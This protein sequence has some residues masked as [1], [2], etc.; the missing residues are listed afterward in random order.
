MAAAINKYPKV[1][2]EVRN[3]WM[4]S[5]ILF[6][7]QEKINLESEAFVTKEKN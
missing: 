7:S 4:L 2:F 5:S 6:G 1:S 3:I